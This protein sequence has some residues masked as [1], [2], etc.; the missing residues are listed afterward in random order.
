MRFIV[1]L[2]AFVGLVGAVWL[3]LTDQEKARLVSA[4]QKK[5]APPIAVTAAVEK[6]AQANYLRLEYA[7]PPMQCVPRTVKAE[8]AEKRGVYR[9]QDEHG[10]WHYGDTP[11]AALPVE[12]LSSQFPGQVKHVTVRLAG[13]G[14]SAALREQ[15]NA[16]A[17]RIFAFYARY[18]PEAG[19]RHLALTVHAFADPDAFAQ[20]R[21]TRDQS[22]AANAGMYDVLER[23]AAVLLSGDAAWDA[24]VIRHEM[25]HA[26]HYELLARPPVWFDEGMAEVFNIVSYRNGHWQATR[27]QEAHINRLAETSG[28]DMLDEF[29]RSDWPGDDPM[30]SYARAWSMAAF[31]LSAPDDALFVKYLR[32]LEAHYCK[33]VDSRAFMAVNYPGGLVQ[34]QSDWAA[35]VQSGSMAWRQ[36][37]TGE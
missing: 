20:W 2:L 22:S 15:A 29:N 3:S 13:K 21:D 25:A 26:I 12:D 24:G 5:T 16:D 10:R 31:L 7:A 30:L 11:P 1:S 6:P 36:R 37:I 35:W 19:K 9:W 18:L 33:P 28:D 4:L 34:W 32:W 27:L 14:V 23:E 8:N 17:E